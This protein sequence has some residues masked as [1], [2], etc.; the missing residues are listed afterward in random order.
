[1]SRKFSGN[2]ALRILI[3]LG[4]EDVV[5]MSSFD[6]GKTEKTLL[7]GSSGRKILTVS[8][9]LDDLHKANLVSIDQNTCILTDLGA[10]K[11]KR[12][13]SPDAPFASQ[14]RT[15]ESKE[16]KLDG[17]AH[18]VAVNLDESPLYRLG[19]RR[20]KNGIPWLNEHHIEAGERL[21]RDFSI[22][23][24]MQ[25]I[26]SSWDPS[27][28]SSQKQGSGS[29]TDLADSAID[30]R[31]RL[32]G[33]LDPLGPELSGVATD[34]CCYLKGLERVERERR[35]PP[36]SAKLMLRTALEMLSR[37]YGLNNA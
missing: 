33:A 1:M 5:R 12:A 28:G 29:K 3:F 30:A 20:G 11:L 15:V 18:K 10:K 27:I 8:H 36:R 13:T 4:D 14:H 17:T 22:G 7:L 26:T 34:V 25:K 37:H 9:A 24:L 19:K 16:I 6:D 35:W 2:A 31:R 21:R 23:Q 32:Y